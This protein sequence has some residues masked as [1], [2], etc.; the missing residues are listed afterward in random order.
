MPFKLFENAHFEHCNRSSLSIVQLA[1]P[2]KY[3]VF[4]NEHYLSKYQIEIN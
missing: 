2:N 4:E 1:K 3:H